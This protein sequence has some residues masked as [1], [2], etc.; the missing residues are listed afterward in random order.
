MFQIM[1]ITA[2]CLDAF[3]TSFAYGI[4]QTKIPI[5][6]MVVIS[7]I[8]TAALVLSSGLGTV[9]KQIIPITITGIICFAILFVIGTIKSFECFLKGYI[10]KHQDNTNQ[11]KVKLFD[12]NFVLSVY[13]ENMKADRDNSKVLSSKEAIYL[14]CALSL[15]GLAAGFGCGLT[16]INYIQLILLSFISNVL[17]VSLGYVVGKY[18][19]KFTSLDFSWLG[20]L[21]LIV[22][23][24]TKLK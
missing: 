23:A 18:V 5:S 19:T 13:A 24:F 4:N 15:D 22:L 16:D 9:A 20:G 6:S 14:A 8:C 21:I 12:V 7:S 11:I 10:S 3:T 1:L 17:A 2:L